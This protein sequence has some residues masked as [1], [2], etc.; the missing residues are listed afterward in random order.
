MAE[1]S[2]D[3]ADLVHLAGVVERELAGQN[4]KGGNWRN[5][6]RKSVG[7]LRVVDSTVRDAILKLGRGRLATCNYDDVLDANATH[8]VT[9]TNSPAA[10][11]V[12]TRQGEGVV[13]LHGHWAT[14]E[15]V[16]FGRDSYEAIKHDEAFQSIQRAI[17]TM[18]SL[19][20]IGFG[21]G[22]S[23]YNIGGLLDWVDETHGGQE[24]HHF[25]IVTN[26]DAGVPHKSTGGATR[27]VNIPC[28]DTH[29]SLGPFLQRLA[30]DSGCD[31]S[32]PIPKPPHP[33]PVR[34]VVFDFGGTLTQ[35]T[36]EMTTWERLW[37]ACGHETLD[38]CHRLHAEYSNG[39]ITH[40][41]W[42]DKTMQS[43]KAKDFSVKHLESI[44][45][46][47]KLVDGVAETLLTLESRDIGLYIV[48]GSIKYL[49]LKTLG[50]L[51]EKFEEIRANDMVFDENGQLKKIKATLYDFDGKAKFLRRVARDSGVPASQILFVGNSSNDL[52]AHSA[53]VQTLVVNP[54]FVDPNDRTVWTNQ[55]RKLTNLQQILPFVT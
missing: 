34:V 8:I 12:L 3:V 51:H 7:A 41:Q 55:I 33:T 10:L 2:F 29:D 16:V 36:G 38:E 47:I 54:R 40:R 35:P 4:R 43:F 18:E 46:D 26:A 49:I 22:I 15:S 42:C 32:P 39:S 50:A 53:G 45:P 25:R 48:S 9:W 24:H 17:A 6:L 31:D 28:G 14:P 11:R 1:D 20:F 27:L 52:H 13:H 5:W 30:A 23:D 19:V 44:L 21:S 37:S